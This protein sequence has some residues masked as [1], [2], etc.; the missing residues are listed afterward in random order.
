[1]G[2][3]KREVSLSRPDIHSVLLCSARP[4]EWGTADGR[5]DG[6]RR[7]GGD[8]MKHTKDFLADHYL[9]HRQEESNQHSSQFLLF[10]TTPA[11]YHSKCYLQQIQRYQ[12]ELRTR[13]EIHTWN[14][15][16][17]S[18]HIMHQNSWIYIYSMHICWMF[19]PQVFNT[20]ASVRF[21]KHMRSNLQQI[22]RNPVEKCKFM[23]FICSILQNT[24]HVLEPKQLQIPKLHIWFVE[25]TENEQSN[26]TCVIHKAQCSIV[27]T[28]ILSFNFLSPKLPFVQR[29]PGHKSWPVSALF[30]PGRLPPLLLS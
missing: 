12:K 18:L 15:I 13:G 19:M 14:Q 24:Q 20:V 7:A 30:G 28:K 4:T 22:L 16:G 3:L 21:S 5:T 10:S 26:F 27:N 25:S 6:Q 11:F 29:S 17:F 8:G 1:M 9:T 23:Q 2:V